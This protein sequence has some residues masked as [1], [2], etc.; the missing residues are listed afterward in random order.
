MRALALACG[1]WT[2]QYTGNILTVSSVAGLDSVDPD[3]VVFDMVQRCTK[4]LESIGV[5]PSRKATYQVACREG[6]APAPTNDVQKA[7]WDEVRKLPEKPIQ[8]KFDP[9]KGR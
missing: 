5:T 6:W 2:S 9:K 7:I 1:S 8:I 3:K 4:H